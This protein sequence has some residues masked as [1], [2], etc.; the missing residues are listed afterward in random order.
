MSCCGAGPAGSIARRCWRGRRARAAARSRPLSARQAVRR[1]DQSRRA[2]DPA[3][4]APDRRR[5]RSRALPLDGMV[6]TGERGVRVALRLRTGVHA[7]SIAAARPRFG[8]RR[9]RRR[10]GARFE[11]GVIVRGP[12]VDDGGVDGA[13]RGVVIAGRDGG[14]SACRRHWSSPPTAGARRWRF[15]S[16]SRA[17]RERPRRWA[18]GAYFDGVAGV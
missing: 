18:I 9:R 17:I 2:G 11:E 7:L 13:C 14:T 3:A 4:L 15:R 6:V 8:A 10:A 16:A 1:H 5:S 12:L